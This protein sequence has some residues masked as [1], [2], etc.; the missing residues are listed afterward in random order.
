MAEWRDTTHRPAG[1]S[2]FARWYRPKGIDP[3]KMPSDMDGVLH[4]MVGNRFLMMEFKPYNG[5]L[6]RGQAITLEGFSRLPGCTSVVV[7]DPHSWDR[8]GELY[9]DRETLRV[10]IYHDG[11]PRSMEVKVRRFNR[12]I[13]EWFEGTG[14]L[15]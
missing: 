3:R 2:D 14:P 4:T 12:L 7:F 9:G 10:V 6:P 8:S 11:V 5:T 15:A 13:R 1:M